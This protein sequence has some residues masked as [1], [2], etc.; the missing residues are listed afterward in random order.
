MNDLE[1]G[2]DMH[3]NYFSRHSTCPT[4]R[5]YHRR[6]LD[7]SEHAECVNVGLMNQKISSHLHLHDDVT[8]YSDVMIMTSG[9][10][11]TNLILFI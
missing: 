10:D 4:H 5:A 1:Y 7:D 11:V 2:N 6:P 9:Q 3:A 8:S